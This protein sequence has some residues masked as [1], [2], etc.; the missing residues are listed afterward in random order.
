MI[1]YDSDTEAIYGIPVSSKACTDYVIHLVKSI[2]DELGYG[3]VK[4]ALKCDAAPELLLLRQ[5][6]REI[7]PVPTVPIDVPVK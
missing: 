5:R 4:I 6:L 1:L 2:I 7:R 3:D